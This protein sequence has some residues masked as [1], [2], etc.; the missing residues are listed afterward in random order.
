VTTVQANFASHTAV[1]ATH[2]Q[3]TAN[4]AAAQ[5]ASTLGRAAGHGAGADNAAP[6]SSAATS[7]QPV[8]NSAKLTQAMG[9]SE[10]RVGM[11]SN[12][13][14]NISINTSTVKDG[15][16][17]QISVDHSE[18]AKT[19]AAHLPEMQARLGSSQQMDVRIDMN[20]ER[21]GHGT[22]TAAG[23]SNGSNG[24][25]GANGSN[26]SGGSGDDARG[27]RRQTS[28]NSSSQSGSGYSGGSLQP[29]A[30]T[31]VTGDGRYNSRLDV[32]V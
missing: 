32:R 21:T 20:G 12:E 8:V 14:G 7:T 5:T 27:S 28:G 3:N 16:S 24:A 10:M 23:G 31:A 2:A 11:R 18:L 6:A 30:A 19:L 29:V 13:F 15:I 26:G 9:Q 25:N 22:G 4:D 17:A 1:A